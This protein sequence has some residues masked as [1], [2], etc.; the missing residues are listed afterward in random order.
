MTPY[1]LPC[2]RSLVASNE[3]QENEVLTSG[4]VTRHAELRLISEVAPKFDRKTIEESTL[5]R[6]TEPWPEVRRRT[7]KEE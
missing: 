7:S 4:D 5:Y 2:P 1:G 3:A 6:S